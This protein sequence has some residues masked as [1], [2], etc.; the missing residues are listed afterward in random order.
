[1]HISPAPQPAIHASL[2][3]LAAPPARDAAGRVPALWLPLRSSVDVWWLGPDCL[4]QQQDARLCAMEH[5]LDLPP[6]PS[7]AA[8]RAAGY[9]DLGAHWVAIDRP[10]MP[11]M[12][13]AA[14]DGDCAALLARARQLFAALAHLERH[15]IVHGDIGPDAIAVDVARGETVFRRFGPATH[16]Q[17]LGTATFCAP[18]E[19]EYASPE[20]LRGGPL[21]ARTDVYSLAL[22][23]MTWF[24]GCSAEALPQVRAAKGRD[25]SDPIAELFSRMLSPVLGDRP[26]T[27]RRALAELEL[28]S[29]E[30][31]GDFADDPMP[32]T[33]AWRSRSTYPSSMAR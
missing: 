7:I 11:S 25:A 3:L 33:D 8:V 10:P 17:A 22:T 28:A 16:R 1:M 2:A 13:K 15:G 24:H 30:C 18:T 9:T 26:R 19:P 20:R 12:A 5:C 31:E 29:G 6:H 23:L 4:D 32:M 21:T 14:S 27:A